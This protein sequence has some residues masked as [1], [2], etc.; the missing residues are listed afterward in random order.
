MIDIINQLLQIP[1]N[2]SYNE[3]EDIILPN[4]WCGEIIYIFFCIKD[5]INQR[6]HRQEKFSNLV[7]QIKIHRRWMKIK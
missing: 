6:D 5:I 7:R 4:S 1:T 2:D 3:T